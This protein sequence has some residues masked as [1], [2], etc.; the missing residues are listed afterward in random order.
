M[1]LA[2][3]EDVAILAHALA[4]ADVEAGADEVHSASLGEAQARHAS[5]VQARVQA[6]RLYVYNACNVS[7]VRKH[8]HADDAYGIFFWVV[9][10]HFL[11]LFLSSGAGAL[12]ALLSS[13]SY[14]VIFVK[15]SSMID[16]T[17]SLPVSTQLL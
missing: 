13:F 5:S 6:C 4:A 8:D 17:N 3:A 16:T 9:R 11:L 2:A 12:S 14:P 15:H 1:V 7:D 10:P